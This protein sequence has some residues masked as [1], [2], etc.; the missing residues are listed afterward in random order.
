M[1]SNINT[2]LEKEAKEAAISFLLKIKRI[3]PE[4]ISNYPYLVGLRL[5]L[6]DLDSKDMDELIKYTTVEFKQPMEK[7]AGNCRQILKEYEELEN[8]P[9]SQTHLK[10]RIKNV[11]SVLQELLDNFDTKED[12]INSLEDKED[13]TKEEIIILETLKTEKEEEGD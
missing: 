10:F 8:N 11:V 3:S 4:D 7:F 13:K 2:R 1:S 9:I 5:E 12:L 6:M